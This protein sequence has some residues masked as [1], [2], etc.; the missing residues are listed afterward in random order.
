MADSLTRMKIR[1]LSTILLAAR[2]ATSGLAQPAA[3][4]YQGADAIL[5][6]VA[7][8]QTVLNS[9]D[10]NPAPD[11]E[12]RA[13]LKS[14]GQVSGTLAP[15][16][17]AKQWLGLVDRFNQLGESPAGGGRQGAVSR[18]I[19]A[20]QLI[21]ALP[22]PAT[23]ANLVIAVE[24]RP[25]GEGAQALHELG[26]RLLVHT[27]T[28]DD[29]KRRGDLAALEARAAKAKSSQVF[30]F[31]ALF[32]EL[33]NSLL[34]TL[35]NPDAIL[36]ILDR[37]LAVQ[38]SEE[39]YHSP[40]RV[41]DLVPLVGREKTEAFLRKALLKS[42][43]PLEVADGTATAG[44]A[45]KLALELIKNL[46][47]P[48]WSL[49]N[50]LDAV[51]L[52]E[53]MER[54]FAPPAAR[55]LAPEPAGVPV[56]TTRPSDGIG[57]SEKSS[58][59]VYY[60]LGLIARGR[61]TD[62]VAVVKQ[63][64]KEEQVG[65]PGEVLRQMERAGF[66][67]QLNAFLHELLQQ[68]PE[69]PLWDEYVRAAAHAGETAEMVK[70]VRATMAR[71]GLSKGQQVRLEQLLYQALLANDEL[72][73]GVAELR[74][75]IQ[76]S[77]QKSPARRNYAV[78]SRSDLGLK[79]ARIGHLTNRADWVTEGVAAV[80]EAIQKK[81]GPDDSYWGGSPELSLAVLL[82][83]L[84]RGPEAEEVMASA[85][86][87]AASRKTGREQE[88]YAGAPNHAVP[89]LAALVQLYDQ[90]G[91]SADV[92]QLF[93]RAPY[94]G[95]KDLAQVDGRLVDVDIF[96][97]SYSVKHVAVPVGY[98]A[99]AALS[100]T[101]HAAEA[102]TLLDSLFD[103]SPGSDRLYELLLAMD[104]EHAPAKLDALFA[105]DQFEERPLIWKAHWLR[106]HQRL[107][108]AE[109][110]ARRAIAIDPTDGEEGPG[111]RLRAYAE[112]AEIRAAR[113]DQKEAAALRG[114]V[115]AVRQAEAADG[116]YAVGMLKRAVAM[117]RDSLDHF[118]DAYCI[119]ARLAVQLSDLGLHEQAEEH[120]RRAYELMP[121]SFGRVESHCFGCERAFD[122][123]RAQGIA[124]KVFAQL[125]QKTPDKPQVHYLLGY[126]REE[127]GRLQE[128][129]ASF[130]VAVKLDPDYLNAW[131]KIDSIG[132][133]LY[134]P[135]AE[136]DAVAFNIL[137]LDP[138]HR[139][140]QPS[141]EV[142]ADLA[143]LWKNVAAANAKAAP[144]PE[145]LY[146]L[147]ASRAEVEKL[148]AQA[149][150]QGMLDEMKYHAFRWSTDE[151]ITPGWAI[152][153]NVFVR[154][155]LRLFGGEGAAVFEE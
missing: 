83:K 32:E 11:E 112:L 89:I 65:F 25:P 119:H 95:A 26:L 82:E 124:E 132:G 74:H 22:P 127:Q 134:L 57:G 3:V 9:A 5:S 34:A 48:Q 66:A 29:A 37:Q 149:K 55:E 33:N 81:N 23:W 21:E 46:K 24:A 49:V 130:R 36:Q 64:E 125:A 151:A 108:E 30:L 15:A 101:G 35:D 128:A 84:G 150:N 8:A 41:P 73:A 118:A 126:L 42:D 136:R 39:H 139:R 72:E 18:P 86:A 107:E 19:E 135:P 44:L 14:F 67:A 105:R 98:Y 129:L 137:R 63:F 52:Y 77:E 122:G 68:N 1:A 12:L 20:Q 85:L 110:T 78:E 154:A 87:E 123:E 142:V 54:R 60:F 10:K 92:L 62:A 103:Q 120:Y 61:T 27:L 113:G 96:I 70:L 4:G 111:D 38:Q 148:E 146:P 28:G 90:A 99:A 131:A 153:Q 138:L 140:G 75:L 76:T 117:Y 79:L 94:W 43:G 59:R 31:N 104:D 114:A 155:A 53:A 40:L 45:R 116:F 71:D 6:Q 109:Q 80:R 58:A 2:L 13:D 69:L 141:L 7:K 145:S 16:E 88:A 144:K 133:H 106:Q 56:L 51:D 102:R 152:A 17:A 115:Q 147:P 91:R 97:P 50:S 121:D 143:A 100:R 47:T 93:D